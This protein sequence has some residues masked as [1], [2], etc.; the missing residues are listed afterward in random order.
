[1]RAHTRVLEAAD[2][3]GVGVVQRPGP[4]VVPAHLVRP[5]AHRRQLPA[6]RRRQQVLHRRGRLLREVLLRR[7][8]R[9]ASEFRTIRSARRVYSTELGEGDLGDLA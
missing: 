4:V 7:A 1:L 8:T 5:R 6:R 2:F 3:G 9:E